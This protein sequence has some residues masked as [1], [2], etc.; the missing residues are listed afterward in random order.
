M[1]VV[2]DYGKR[3]AKR[4]N[5][6]TVTLSKWVKSIREILK[7]RVRNIKTKVRTIYSSVFSKPEVK[8][9]LKILHEEFVCVL[10]DKACNNIVFVWL[11][12]TTVS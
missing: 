11:N 6:E 4:K 5:E 1:N 2:E 10:A 8:N 12:I 9:E 3:L 7:S